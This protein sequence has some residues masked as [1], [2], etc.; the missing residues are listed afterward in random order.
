MLP[1]LETFSEEDEGSEDDESEEDEG[2]EDNESD[3][4]ELRL[5]L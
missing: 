5:A 3:D 1:G 2:S 4:L